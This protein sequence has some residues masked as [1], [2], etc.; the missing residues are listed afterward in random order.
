MIEFLSNWWFL[1]LMLS[2][3]SIAVFVWLFLNRYRLHAK[4]WELLIVTLLH[5]I[6][7]VF[8]VKFRALLEAGFDV[9]TAGNMSLFGGVFIMPLTYLIYAILKKLP[10]NDVFDI[11]TVSLV[12]TLFFAR[13]N[14]FYSGCCFGVHIGDSSFEYPTREFELF[15]YGVFLIFAVPWILKRKSC[16]YVLPL[17]FMTYGL[18]RFIGERFRYS[19]ITD[20]RF[21]F[22]H[23]WAIVIF[24]V[25]SLWLIIK[26]FYFDKRS[27]RY[28]K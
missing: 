25:G 21:H 19:N 7:G 16:G 6:I 13:I 28:D 22:G 23:L 4:W 10:F 24:V 8:T 17:Y 12:G 15:Y 14:C 11:M 9:D 3:A 18:D 26:K 2:L 1:I 20:S 27:V 5:T